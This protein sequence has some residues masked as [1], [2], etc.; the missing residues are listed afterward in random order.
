MG[1]RH[2][3]LPPDTVHL[4]VD[5]QNLFAPGGPWATPWFPR[6][7]PQIEMLVARH[8]AATVFSRFI[9]PLR[10]DELPGAWMRYYRRWRDVTR[11]RVDPRLLELTPALGAHAPP[12]TVIDKQRYS[13]FHGSGL[14]ALLGE[15]GISTLVVSGTETDVC[16]LS[17]VLDAVDLGYRVV[18]A[19]DA[20]CSSSD[21]SHDAALKLYE[22]RFSEQVETADVA[23]IQDA[24]RG[25]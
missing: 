21:E 14:R 15:R 2:G 7:L 19:R 13:A 25:G 9:P 6:V 4:C 22:Q 24:W 3:E 16:V 1:L 20:I 23:E 17:S 12:A 5:M 18:L 8:P 11:E 10:P